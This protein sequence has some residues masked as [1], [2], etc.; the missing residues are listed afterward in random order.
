MSEDFTNVM[1]GDEVKVTRGRSLDRISKVYHVTTKTFDVEGFG[2]FWKHNGKGHGDADSWYGRYAY[3]IERGD[4]IRI[5]LQQE[6]VK[7]TNL[8]AEHRVRDFDHDELA[9]VAEI[10]RECQARRAKETEE[11][12]RKHSADSK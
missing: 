7:N 5:E 1:I 3:K 10:I 4:R 11:Y 12:D 6:R 8:Y 9:R 2:R